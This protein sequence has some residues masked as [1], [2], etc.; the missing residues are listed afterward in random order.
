MHDWSGYYEQQGDKPNPAVVALVNQFEGE[1][2]SALD[3]GAGNFRDARYIASQGFS[4]VVAVEPS[5]AAKK[6]AVPG[7]E[8][9]NMP[10]QAFRSRM[11]VFNLAISCNT[12][13]HLASKKEVGDVFGEVFNCLTPGGVFFCNL[14]DIE[15]A[16]FVET[17]IRF[18]HEE[19]SDLCKM[20][21]SSNVYQVPRGKQSGRS[22]LCRQWGLV[23][24]K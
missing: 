15:D 8:F 6:F 5:P 12:L 4:K 24:R 23:L 2:G 13:F 22:R 17:K 11:N 14:L 18:S 19:I 10:A 7:I 3:L 16:Y 9:L 21:S 1:R 20:F